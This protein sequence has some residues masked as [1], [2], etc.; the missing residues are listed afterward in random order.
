MA[1]DEKS[2]QVHEGGCLCGAL[3]YKVVGEPLGVAICHCVNCQRNSGSAFS[4]NAT[5]PAGTMTL[6]GHPSIYDD[7][8][9]T[10]NVVR[11][12]FCGICGTPIESQSVYSIPNYVVIKAGTFDDPSKFVPDCE[13]YCDSKLPWVKLG[14]E[15]THHNKTNFDSIETMAEAIKEMGR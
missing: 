8:G 3:R 10:G 4:L 6:E 7:A 9:D 11:R 14:E 13:V 15:I 1:T 2:V 12:V 5:F